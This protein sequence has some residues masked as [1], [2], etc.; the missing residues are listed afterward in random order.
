MS[1]S[2][3]KRAKSDNLDCAMVDLKYVFMSFNFEKLL[4]HDATETQN[5]QKQF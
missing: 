3:D 4:S 5:C 1:F 2:I